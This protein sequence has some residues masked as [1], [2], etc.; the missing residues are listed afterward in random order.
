[1]AEEAKKDSDKYLEFWKTFG[2]FL[3]EGV[4]SDFEYQKE[5]STLLRL[6]LPPL[7]RAA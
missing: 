5:L 6:S 4:T 3:K 1:M 7:K 2:I